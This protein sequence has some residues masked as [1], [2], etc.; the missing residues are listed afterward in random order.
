[1]ARDLPGIRYFESYAFD[2]GEKK[3]LLGVNLETVY[4]RSKKGTYY[5]YYLDSKELSK[6]SEEQIQEPTF[7]PDGK[8]V[9][10]V[11]ENNLYVLDLE[12]GSVDQVTQDGK[13]NHIINGQADWVYEEE[14]SLVRAFEWNSDSDRIAF[15]RF[16]ESE[17]PE[18]SMDMYGQDLYPKPHVFKY[19]KAGQKNSSIRL[20]LYD[21]KSGQTVEPD[22]GSLNQEY[23]P[24]IKW[25][26]DPNSL[27]VTTLN[28]HQNN[29]NLV[30]IDAREQ[31]LETAS[32]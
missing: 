7:S 19:P 18:F 20:F 10:Y 17:V 15:L 11:F 8:K 6:V 23:I 13:I 21:L 5:V 4:R 25:T 22:L 14:F 9:A 3:L 30:L 26:H 31:Q 29:L 24:R 28:R 2:L 32:Q 27:V 16:D 1:M 12:T